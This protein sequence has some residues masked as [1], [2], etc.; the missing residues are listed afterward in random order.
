[1][2]DKAKKPAAKPVAKT[3][4]AEG[5]ATK[6]KKPHAGR[7]KQLLGGVW[8]FGKSRMYHK[9][10]LWKVNKTVPKKE[11]P[12]RKPRTVV[13][14]IGGEKNGG[15]RLVKL[16]KQVCEVSVNLWTLFLSIVSIYRGDTI[17]QKIVL[18]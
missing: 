10:G 18:S 2:S 12:K 15:K 13:K 14:P 8:R 3:P 4:K 17:R 11:K 16:K 9:R 7:N 6:V 5:A 1:M